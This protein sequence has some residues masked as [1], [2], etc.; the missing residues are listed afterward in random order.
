MYPWVRIKTWENANTY[1]WVCRFL[2]KISNM[3]LT[4]DVRNGEFVVFVLI[5]FLG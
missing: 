1:L 3:A 2:K 5:A 4:L